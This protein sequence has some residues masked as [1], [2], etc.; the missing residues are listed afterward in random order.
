MAAI[1][2][3]IAARPAAADSLT[4]HDKA[5]LAIIMYERTCADCRNAPNMRTARWRFASDFDLRS[6]T[7]TAYAFALIRTFAGD[8]R[9]WLFAY[10][11][12]RGGR[13]KLLRANQT[14]SDRFSCDTSLLT[15]P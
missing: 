12:Y 2:A 10:S 9:S 11:P 6:G 5:A 13:W 8:T 1:A 14:A 15:N 7:Q 3:G 4:A